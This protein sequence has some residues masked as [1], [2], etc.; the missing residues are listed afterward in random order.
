[1]LGPIIGAAAAGED[2]ASQAPPHNTPRSRDGASVTTTTTTTMSCDSPAARSD[3]AY[4][5][6]G[7]PRA[8]QQQQ[9]AAGE[10]T[11]GQLHQ[12]RER[13]RRDLEAGPERLELA[14]LLRPGQGVPRVRGGP[15]GAQDTARYRHTPMKHDWAAGRSPPAVEVAAV[16]SGGRSP[17]PPP[18][19]PPPPQGGG[20]A[21][22]VGE[23]GPVGPVVR[24]RGGRPSD[25]DSDSDAAAAVPRYARAVKNCRATCPLDALLLDFL[26]ERRQRA[27][28][29]LPGHEVVGPPYP[30][31]SSLLCPGNSAYSHPLSKV[32]TDILATFPDIS[33][34]PERV[35]VL[36]VMFL[37]ARWQVSPT[38]DSFDRLPAWMRPCAAQVE[39][40]HPAWIDHVPFPRMRDRLV[41][42][43]DPGRYLFANFFVPFTTTLRLGWPYGGADTLLLVADSDEL[44]I[45]PVFE[46]HLRNLDNWSLG[47]PFV[48]AFPALA[49]TCNVAPP[50]PS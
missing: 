20:G 44:V 9:Q 24:R 23:V 50:D 42:D 35:A 16:L 48:R 14:F 28:E 22:L 11:L 49:D 26:A 5:S 13:L 21:G 39:L 46:R 38:R 30:S 40:P 7:W 34:L 32:F 2:G 37:F 36:Y 25:P 47:Q 3:H 1:M 6:P 15:H 27:A 33:A 8:E 10:A 4:L 17:P 29:G 12:Q 31:V 18:P 19:P 45:N 41:R 43:Y